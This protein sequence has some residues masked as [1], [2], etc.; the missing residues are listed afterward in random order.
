MVGVLGFLIIVATA[1]VSV[2]SSRREAAAAK[3]V[4][5]RQLM[6]ELSEV[7]S[8]DVPLAPSDLEQA[9][10]PASTVPT[11]AVPQEGLG[12]E[13]EAGLLRQAPDHAVPQ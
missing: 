10:H 8:P 9:G 4:G 1:L 12:D 7:G 13:E 5:R 11:A 6:R 3:V 2:A